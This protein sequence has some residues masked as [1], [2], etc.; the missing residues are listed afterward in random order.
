MRLLK[1][2]K[3]YVITCSWVGDIPNYALGWLKLSNLAREYPRTLLKVWNNSGN[4]VM[5]LTDKEHL[6]SVKEGLDG[7]HY[8]Y[9]KDNKPHS[10][11]E[12]VDVEE[13]LYGVVSLDELCEGENY[14]NCP[15]EHFIF[16]D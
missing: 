2:R 12:V 14:D 8:W 5:V 4:S 1:K 7:F 6:E 15:Q 10:L 11:S 3:G 13:V 9:D 16:D